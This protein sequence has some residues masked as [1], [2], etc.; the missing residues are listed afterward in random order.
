[1]SK[2]ALVTGALCGIGHSNDPERLEVASA[3]FADTGMADFLDVDGTSAGGEDQCGRRPLFMRVG[4]PVR[5]LCLV[6]SRAVADGYR[7]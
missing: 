4:A 7:A 5:G 3:G 1:M 6:V 2:C